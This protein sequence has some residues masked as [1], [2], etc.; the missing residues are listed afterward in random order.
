[1]LTSCAYYFSY[2]FSNKKLKQIYQYFICF[3]C[4]L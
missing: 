2:N 1:M 4:A 3:F